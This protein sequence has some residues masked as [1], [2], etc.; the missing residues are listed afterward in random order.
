[1]IPQRFSVLF[2]ALVSTGAACAP[3]PSSPSSPSSPP[4]KPVP[5]AAASS[6]SVA[7]PA[8]P[9][10]GCEVASAQRARVSG[11]LAQGRLDRAVRVIRRADS[12][13]S[14]QQGASRA[15]LVSTLADLALWAETRQVADEI[16]RDPGA[17]A[18]AKAASGQA[19][20]K[21]AQLDKP[22]AGTPEARRAMQHAWTEAVKQRDAGHL[23]EAAKLFVQAWESWP[24]NGQALVE[25]GMVKKKSGEPAEGQRLLDRGIA[26]LEKS[27]G[28]RAIAAIDGRRDPNDASRDGASVAWTAGNLLAMTSF[29]TVAM[30]TSN[31]EQRLL[32]DGNDLLAISP[33]GALLASGS[34]DGIHLRDSATGEE[35]ASFPYAGLGDVEEA[36][37]LA[38][39]PDG[40][41]L[42]IA[43]LWRGASTAAGT[44]ASGPVVALVQVAT[45]KVLFKSQWQPDTRL[46]CAKACAKRGSQQCAV[47]ESEMV[48]RVYSLAF[49]PN[50]KTLAAGSGDGRVRMWDVATGKEAAALAGVGPLAFS[51]D[52]KTLAAGKQVKPAP[53]CQGFCPE[54]SDVQVWD[55]AGRRVVRTF[56]DD[57]YSLNTV[58]FA[59]DGASL[60]TAGNA[61]SDCSGWCM[62]SRRVAT[63]DVATGRQANAIEGPSEHPANPDAVAFSPDGKY[64]ATVWDD[65]LTTWEIASGKAIASLPGFLGGLSTRKFSSGISPTR[66]VSVSS[67]DFPAA[68]TVRVLDLAEGRELARFAPR[69]V[70]PGTPVISPDGATLLLTSLRQTEVWPLATG[71]SHSGA[72]AAGPQAFSPDGK[73]LA[74][75]CDAKPCL[76]LVQ[77][78]AF[79]SNLPWNL[80]QPTTMAFSPNGRVMAIGTQ[81]GPVHLWST[82]RGA[83]VGSLQGSKSP[84][85]AVA[86]S[87]DGSRL[88]SRASDGMVRLWDVATR[89]EI[90][91]AS[92]SVNDSDS[93]IAFSPGGKTLALA[94]DKSVRLWDTEKGTDAVKL[95]GHTDTVRSVAFS[96]DGT[97]LVSTAGEVIFWSV[98]QGGRLATLTVAGVEDASTIVTPDGFVD[99]MGQASPA[100]MLCRIGRVSFPLEACEDRVVVRGLLA[101][102]MAGDRSYQVP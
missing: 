7:S 53:L 90:A 71:K 86:F 50:G 32:L 35:L 61:P 17:S 19:R 44:R 12:L 4:P 81:D 94:D 97:V 66:L 31:L 21:A 65:T 27:T 100:R 57:G 48:R 79:P 74:A 88:A 52:G 83:V 23:P 84:I 40:T 59:P 78:G 15:A 49:S 51:P 56:H 95:Q 82:D 64:A 29:G 67:E 39:S 58:A 62:T 92:A 20:A 2:A 70:S 72:F 33:D 10:S 54:I 75:R 14:Q 76:A 55:L 11:L 28:E 45:G 93:S 80:A 37:A 91:K 96:Q 69:E 85:S 98:A 36:T 43:A 101:K 77:A 16:D 6:A 99:V 38:F 42:A 60:F 30:L 24:T 3:V 9:P 34:T 73:R 63:W 25:A 26:Q 1:M 8:K 68:T 46:A 5:A 87:P 41:S 18:E 89:K 47:C 102:V 22:F 13:C